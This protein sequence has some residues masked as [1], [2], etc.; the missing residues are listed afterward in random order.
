MKK[1]P[2]KKT[3]AVKAKIVGSPKKIV[4]KPALKTAAPRKTGFSPEI[5]IHATAEILFQETAHLFMQEAR[6]AV[7]SRGRFVTG[8]Q[9]PPIPPPAGNLGNDVPMASLPGTRTMAEFPS[10]PALSFAD[11]R[12]SSTCPG[13]SFQA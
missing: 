1:V 10:L 12:T 11:T 13:L 6:A 2:N 3:K 7:A 8:G 4:G 5:K 9:S